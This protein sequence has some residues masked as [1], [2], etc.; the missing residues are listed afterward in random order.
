MVEL[1]TALVS[2]AF[3][4]SAGCF[5]VALEMGLKLWFPEDR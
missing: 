5:A 2:A 4:F 1:I 3:M